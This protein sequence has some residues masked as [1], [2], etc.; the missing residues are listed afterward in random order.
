[1]PTGP[2][3]PLHSLGLGGDGDEVSAIQNVER[4]F[5]VRLDYDDAPGWWTVGDV[6]ASLL[7]ALPADQR[8]DT[9]VWQR[10]TKAITQETGV[11]A[12]SIAPETLL[13]GQGNR[14]AGRL[15]FAAAIGLGAAAAF[16]NAG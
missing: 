9:D 6:H 11:D 16:W 12:T 2:E 4:A 14:W 10:L 3:P 8:D 15:A 1:M 7:R 13:I 5:G